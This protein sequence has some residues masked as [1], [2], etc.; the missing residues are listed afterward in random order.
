MVFFKVACYEKERKKEK[1]IFKNAG[2]LLANA[3]TEYNS[4]FL[5]MQE[6]GGYGTGLLAFLNPYCTV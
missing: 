4:P 1:V 3:N 5:N 2:K 6:G